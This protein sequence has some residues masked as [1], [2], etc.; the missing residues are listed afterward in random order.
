MDEGYR[1]FLDAEILNYNL[2]LDPDK[3]VTRSFKEHKEIVEKILEVM[4]K[5]YFTTDSARRIMNFGR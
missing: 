4:G 1:K 2:S 3:V 5:D